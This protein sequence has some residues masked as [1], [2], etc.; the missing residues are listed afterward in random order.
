MSVDL[1]VNAYIQ[2]KSSVLLKIALFLVNEDVAL[3]R[4]S[5]FRHYLNMLLETG[6]ACAVE[7]RKHGLAKKK[8][9]KTPGPF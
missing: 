1:L 4:T 3:Q 5:V 8:K 6:P 9:D 2:N 7:H